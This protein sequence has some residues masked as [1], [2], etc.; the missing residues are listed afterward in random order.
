MLVF[1]VALLVE[2][3]YL[4]SLVKMPKPMMTIMTS[5]AG[6]LNAVLTCR[7]EEISYDSFLGTCNVKSRKDLMGDA[8]NQR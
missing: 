3:A 4:T 8:I 2:I 7:P 6:M 5:L 1:S